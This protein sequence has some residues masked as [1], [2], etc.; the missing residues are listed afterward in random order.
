[1]G[2]DTLREQESGGQFFVMPR[3]AHGDDERPTVHADLKR[4]FNR[5]G[6]RDQRAAWLAY[7]HTTDTGM[8][9]S[10]GTGNHTWDSSSR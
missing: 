4:S 6:V 2:H 8:G 5:D 7:L 9:L 1:M 3:R 10:D